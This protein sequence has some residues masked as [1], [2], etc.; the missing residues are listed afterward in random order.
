M[1]Q[2][3]EELKDEIDQL[4]S[5]Q[6]HS[7]TALSENLA[8]INNLEKKEIEMTD[9]ICNLQIKFDEIASEIKKLEF[10]ANLCLVN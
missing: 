2:T 4:R 3:T 7:E 8:K 5:E 1:E 9:N 6:E 10:A